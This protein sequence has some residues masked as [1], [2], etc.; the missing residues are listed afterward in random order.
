MANASF[1]RA[2]LD[3]LIDARHPLA[4]LAGRMPWSDIETIVEPIMGGLSTH[5]E[6]VPPVRLLVALLYLAHMSNQNDESVVERWAQDVYFQWFSG[7]EVFEPQ[8]PCDAAQIGRFREAL[9]DSRLEAVLHD[10]LFDADP[11]GAV[12]RIGFGRPRSRHGEENHADAQSAA[13]EIYRKVFYDSPDFISFCRMDDTYIDVNPGFERFV[14]LPRE[15]IIGRTSLDIGLWPGSAQRDAFVAE[16]RARQD[17]LGYHRRLSRAN[18][19]VRE[20]EGWASIVDAGDEEVLVAIGRDVTQRQRDASELR[21]YRDRLEQLVDLR[22]RE[23]SDANQRLQV[24]DRAKSAFLA[25]M[26]HELRTP[27]NAI[28]G[29]AQLLKMGRGLN[30]RQIA[31]LN[32]IEQGG[33][34]LLALINDILDLAR[35]EAGKLDLFPTPVDLR[36]FMLLIV[37]IIRVRAQEKS[38][39]FRHE[40]APDLPRTVLVDEKRLRQI[41]LNLLGN[42]VKFTDHGEVAFS[43]SSQARDGRTVLCFEVSD[44]GIGIPEHQLDRLFK[45]FEQVSDAGHRAGGAGL[46]LSISQ[47]L[48]RLMGGEIGV[49]KIP[50][51]GTR[52]SFELSLPVLDIVA[53][54]RDAGRAV[55]GY[56]GRRRRVLIVDDI[57]QNRAMLED[58]LQLLGF[59]T[60]SAAG[61]AEAL[62]QVA[63]AAPDMVLMDVVMPEMDGLETTRRLRA[64][65]AMAGVPIVA[66]SASASVWQEQACLAAGADSYL[67]KPISLPQLI[68]RISQLLSLVW[69][70]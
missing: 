13:L 45:P 41:L 51:G 31:G 69:T 53:P 4:T 57:E 39:L 47:A 5:G 9:R 27:L 40:A 20:I 67:T 60:S 28:L 17:M 22:T 32:T 46:G 55:R 30:D 7:Q 25:S 24:A 21:Q 1:V 6:T 8:M 66:V 68:E 33:Q 44:T 10:K 29:Y 64:M 43:V 19:E 37:D 35:V 52:F 62:S 26:S 49:S 42:A 65:A 36:V 61:G 59:E 56:E 63:Q 11:T 34:H 18:G 15:R 50:S 38:L 3:T 23:L 70:H 58:A 14:G 16:L 54:E 12:A 48:T 2:R